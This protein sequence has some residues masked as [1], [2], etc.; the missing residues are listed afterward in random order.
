MMFKKCSNFHWCTLRGFDFIETV[1]ELFDNLSFK[2]YSEMRYF[3]KKS[4][5]LLPGIDQTS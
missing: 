1:H 4:S 2:S 3:F 5:S